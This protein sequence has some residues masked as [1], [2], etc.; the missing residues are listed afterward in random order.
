MCVPGHTWEHGFYL[1]RDEFIH[2]VDQW[3]RLLGITRGSTLL[4]CCSDGTRAGAARTLLRDAGFGSVA[5]IRG[6]MQEWRTQN[7]PVNLEDDGEDGLVGS[8][9]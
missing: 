4:L 5:S 1:P 3:F 9:V 7:L 6:G 2:D 8:W